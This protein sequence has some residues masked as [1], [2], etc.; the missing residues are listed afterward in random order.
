MSETAGPWK[1]QSLTRG[2]VDEA[3]SKLISGTHKLH[4]G[5]AFLFPWDT[6]RKADLWHPEVGAEACRGAFVGHA[7]IPQT[8]TDHPRTQLA[9]AASLDPGAGRRGAAGETG[10]QV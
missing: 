1:S 2:L 7:C 4:T 6:R 8:C 3:E 10:E 9:T 5:N